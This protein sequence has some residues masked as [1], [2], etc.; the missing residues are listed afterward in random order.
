MVK[1]VRTR[2][3]GNTLTITIDL[4]KSFGESGSGKSIII[5]TTAG[6]MTVPGTEDIKLGLNCYRPSGNGRGRYSDIYE[7][8]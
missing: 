1:N 8:N 5:A 2:I 6:N 4:S 3:E 7:E